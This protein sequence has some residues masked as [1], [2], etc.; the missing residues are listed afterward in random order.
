MCKN[1][2]STMKRA[3]ANLA[4][5]IIPIFNQEKLCDN[6][7]VS[8]DFCKIFLG[9]RLHVTISCTFS[10]HSDLLDKISKE[11]LSMG[12]IFFIPKR[13][14]EDKKKII[15]LQCT[16]KNFIECCGKLRESE[17]RGAQNREFVTKEYF[18]AYN[19][20]HILFRSESDAKLIMEYVNYIAA[21]TI[22]LKP[23][24]R[25]KKIFEYKLLIK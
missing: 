19:N 13:L 7:E 5:T 15:H 9:K 12:K 4:L 18:P 3:N 11:I 1:I 22:F 14:N 2:H 16:N 23:L 8:K 25:G 24:R 6:S 21:N 20:F 17:L 10:E